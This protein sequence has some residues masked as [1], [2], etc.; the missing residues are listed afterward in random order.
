M[1]AGLLGRL[2]SVPMCP[3]DAAVA[4]T[5][6]E[7][8]RVGNASVSA[9]SGSQP[10]TLPG[11]VYLAAPA[12]AGDVATLAIVVRAV[13]GPIDLGTVVVQSAIRLR[14][15]DSGL[16]IVSDPLPAV[17]GGIP[18]R[19]RAIGVDIDRPG[20]LFNPTSCAPLKIAGTILAAT[21]DTAD[22]SAPF[23]AR[24]CAALPLRPKLTARLGGETKRRGHP[25]FTATI[26]QPEGD[27]HL[28]STA[29]TLPSQLGIDLA[30]ASTSTCTPAAF[31]ADKCPAASR[32]GSA[33]AV[34]PVL[35][36]PLTGPAYLIQAAGFPKL[37]VQLRGQV[38]LDLEGAIAPDSR[39]RLVTTFAAIPDVP[40]SSFQLVVNGGKRAPLLTSAALCSASP[41]ARV[42]FVGHNGKRIDQRVTVPVAKCPKA[43]KRTAKSKKRAAKRVKRAASRR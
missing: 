27:A 22:V 2:A 16:D 42:T 12:H 30:T 39:G 41:A 5:C 43:K 29:V 32:I 24:G 34:T 36:A 6:D 11:R 7:S 3:Q 19:L 40:I 31:A 28:R 20:F 21:G 33:T 38:A 18:L 8:S 1:P 10:L 26:T 25:S 35:A 17:L 4:G 37:V 15:S 9:G 23:Q 13:A 14:P